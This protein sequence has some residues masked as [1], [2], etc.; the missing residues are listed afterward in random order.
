L[1]NHPFDEYKRSQETGTP[2]VRDSAQHLHDPNAP[3]MT[4]QRNPPVVS[5]ASRVGGILRRVF[6]LMHKF[7]TV[8][9]FICA[10]AD[11]T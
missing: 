10:S 1:R 3:L 2:A 5:L 4:F 11:H 9:H 8:V 6:L 7:F